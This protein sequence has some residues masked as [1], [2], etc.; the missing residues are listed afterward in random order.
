MEIKIVNLC[1]HEVV[2]KDSNGKFWKLEACEGEPARV[3]NTFAAAF[4]LGTIGVSQK[5]SSVNVNLPPTTE[6]T[7][8]IVSRAVADANRGRK[9]LMFPGP[10]YFTD[11][12]VKYCVGLEIC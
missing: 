7:M 5:I 6:G 4:Y 9:D 3:Q 8:Y 1:N 2:I 11:D 10:Q 12:G